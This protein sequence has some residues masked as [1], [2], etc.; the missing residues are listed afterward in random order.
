[1]Y[2]EQLNIRKY[3]FTQTYTVSVQCLFVRHLGNCLSQLPEHAQH[4][5]LGGGGENRRGVHGLIKVNQMNI[6]FALLVVYLRDDTKTAS[7]DKN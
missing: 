6:R 4:H 5:L 7:I 3:D 2:Q 1:M